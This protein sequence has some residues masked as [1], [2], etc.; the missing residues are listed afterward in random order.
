MNRKKLTSIIAQ[1][2]LLCIMSLGS[3]LAN[4]YTFGHPVNALQYENCLYG[5][6]TCFNTSK[7]HSAIDYKNN[8][9]HEIVASNFGKIVRIEYMNANDKGMGNNV[10]IEHTLLTGINIYSFYSHLA[11]IES[12]LYVDKIV[13]KGEKI[14]IMG[15]SGYGV[16]NYWSIHLHFEIKD[17]PVTNNPSGDG[18][19]WGY[20][21]NYPDNYGYH[22]PNIYIGSI[23]VNPPH[24]PTLKFTDS[25]TV[26]LKSNNKLW[27]IPNEQTYAL[28]GY[29][30]SNCSLT[31]DWSYVTELPASEK[32]NY[33]IMGK[34]MLSY[35]DYE[36]S[37][38]IAYKVI[39]KV[40]PV[41]CISTAID[42][43]KIYLFG[44]DDKFH[45]IQNEQV[46]Y[47]IGYNPDWSEVVE[48]PPELFNHYGEGD[49]ITE[50]TLSTS[51]LPNF[52]G[53][54]D[55]EEFPDLIP[56][57]PPEDPPSNEECNP[58]QITSILRSGKT[59]TITWTNTNSQVID[60]S[61]Q[62]WENNGPIVNSLISTSTSLIYEEASLVSGKEYKV[63]G[64]T[65]CAGALSSNWS[66]PVFFMTQTISPVE[67]FQVVE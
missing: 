6:K 28:L 29:R 11:S 45:H 56:I 64:K 15:G 61:I 8:A 50:T 48:I 63:I 65:Y 39:S 46:Y 43:S 17:S 24:H 30:N 21:P 57:D 59:L 62:V 7:Y 38:L 9:S 1:I 27:P 19:Y 58:P 67:N 5:L 44:T 60:Y 25:P 35:N 66:E 37:N 51:P 54:T 42:S 3:A 20:T 10:I 22:D 31:P 4:D 2:C 36:W 40:G 52:L 55:E 47:D 16:A 18:L 26:Y 33:Q 13:L 23:L 12:N 41:S 53:R 34:T 49:V 14:G 32:A